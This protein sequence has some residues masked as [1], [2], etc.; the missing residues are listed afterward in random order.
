MAE[1]SQAQTGQSLE[2]LNFVV[3]RLEVGIFAVDADMNIVLWNR[4]MAIHSKKSADEVCGRNLFECF[5][6]LPMPWLK[7]KIRS[8]FL[9]KN[10]AF[11]SWEQRPYLFR[12]KHNRPI[13]GGIETMHQNCTFL[14]IKDARDN[15]K[16]V[17]VTVFDFT[18]T[19][20]YQHQLTTAIKELDRDKEI[21]KSLIAELEKAQGELQKLASF[22]ALTGLA[23]RRSFDI[24]LG[25]EWRRAARDH[26]PLSLLMID[27]DFF[28]LY[29]DAYGHQ[30]GDACLQIVAAS[31]AGADLRESDTAARYGGEEFAVILTGTTLE[32]AASVGERIRRLVEELKIPHKTSEVSA[33]VSVSVGSATMLPINGLDEA[34]LISAADQ[35]LYRAKNEGRNRLVATNRETATAI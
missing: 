7:K 34:E 23:N 24:K 20:L 27:V 9:L 12:F 8:V 31:I 22:D 16:H 1:L 25:T 11:T 13:T 28:K 35:A 17:C 26:T 4:F 6:D 33:T 14:P 30:K 2:L 19:A 5:P 15:V 10:F 18:D 21:Q 32:G 29:N 3:D